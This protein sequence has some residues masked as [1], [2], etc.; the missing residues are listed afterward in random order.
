M[1]GA[2][3]QRNL[4]MGQRQLRSDYEVKST[5]YTLGSVPT[6]ASIPAEMRSVWEREKEALII[7]LVE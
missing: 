6:S 3:P 5:G 1:T 4:Q 7:G 2:S